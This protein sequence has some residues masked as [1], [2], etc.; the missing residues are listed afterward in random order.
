MQKAKCENI[1]QDFRIMNQKFSSFN[2]MICSQSLNFYQIESCD[3]EFS[4]WFLLEL[5][6]EDIH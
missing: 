2:Q 5:N 4:D 3:P 1:V 6:K